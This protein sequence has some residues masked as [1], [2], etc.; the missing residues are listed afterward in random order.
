MSRV[1]RSQGHH[2]VTAHPSHQQVDYFIKRVA[3][4]LSRNP[5]LVMV[6]ESF[7]IDIA[8][9]NLAGNMSQHLHNMSLS[10]N[11][12]N[13]T[14]KSVELFYEPRPPWGQQDVDFMMFHH[15]VKPFEDEGVYYF[16]LWYLGGGVMTKT[17]WD[18][19]GWE[20]TKH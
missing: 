16:D 5:N 9:P 10:L 14:D 6:F 18:E 13:D 8:Q 19:E 4:H 2:L 1:I 17:E 12:F 3:E 15:L 20:K 7:P 11:N